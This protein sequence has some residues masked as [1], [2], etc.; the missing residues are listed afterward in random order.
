[1]HPHKQNG[2]VLPILFVC[3]IA[4]S[5]T[6]NKERAKLTEVFQDAYERYH[7]ASGVPFTL[8]QFTETLDKYDYESEISFCY[9][10][11]SLLRNWGF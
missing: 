10:F 7:N 3:S 5:S 4:I 9:K 8:E 1:M 6:Q 11:V 2:G